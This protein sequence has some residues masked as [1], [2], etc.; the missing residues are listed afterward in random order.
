[1]ASPRRRK[2]VS[3]VYAEL[4]CA[5]PLERIELIRRG[6]PP[7]LILDLACDLRLSEDNLMVYLGLV[8]AGVRQKLADEER[9]TPQESD[10]VMALAVF[11]GDT[12][13]GH[14]PVAALPADAQMAAAAWLGRWLRSPHVE[15]EHRAPLQF[16][17]I[18]HG[19]A[20]VASLLAR[21]RNARRR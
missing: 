16:V 1:M 11:L 9:L 2:G 7:A 20:F 18:P 4:A 15:L 5:T 12:L 17:D 10:G 19:R 13:R 3:P 21:A 14:D 8:R 6:L